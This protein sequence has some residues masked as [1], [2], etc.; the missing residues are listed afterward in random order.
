MDTVDLGD[1]E[2]AAKLRRLDAAAAPAS[3]GFDYAGMLDRHVAGKA[4]ARR[5]LAIARGTASALV[6]V[7][8]AGSAWRFT[9]TDERAL[10]S[11]PE[12]AAETFSASNEEEQPR[13]VRADTYLALAALEDH[14]ATI[15]DALSDARLVSPRGAEVARLERTRAELLDSYDLVR[16]ADRVSANF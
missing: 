13:L 3:P 8:I 7:V 4:R 2:L 12:A 11:M 16:Y 15:D 10:L 9:A 6:L 14:I 5:R 1:S